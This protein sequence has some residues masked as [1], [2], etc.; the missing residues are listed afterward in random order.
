MLVR[1]QE[2]VQI[3]PLTEYPSHAGNELLAVGDQRI[4]GVGRNLLLHTVNRVAER[5]ALAAQYHGANG[6][7]LLFLDE[8][9]HDECCLIRAH[10]A[11]LRVAHEIL[12]HVLA[13]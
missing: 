11:R 8:I 7:A 4:C 1:L 3:L 10:P 5:N 9:R 13:R 12:D 2:H 6:D